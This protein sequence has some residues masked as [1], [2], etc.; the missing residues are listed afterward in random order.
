MG[1]AM[2]SPVKIV[3]MGCLL[4]MLAAIASSART[5]LHQMH[6]ILSFEATIALP[7]SPGTAAWSNDGRFLAV[8]QPVYSGTLRVVDVAARKLTDPIFASN[9]GPSTTVAWS[10]DDKV[11]A[12]VDGQK[13][14]FVKHPE[15]SVIGTVHRDPELYAFTNKGAASFTR[16]G[17]FV[18]VGCMVAGSRKPKNVAAIKIELS[19]MSIVD[20]VQL[21][22]PGEGHTSGWTSETITGGDGHIY[23]LTTNTFWPT[24]GSE[25]P[26]THRMYFS[27]FDLTD[28]K[29][30]VKNVIYMPRRNKYEDANGIMYLPASKKLALR[31]AGNG[32]LAIALSSVADPLGHRLIKPHP[33]SDCCKFY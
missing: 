14:R 2:R 12:I 28:Q 33:N 23:L 31:I 9:V 29:F 13:V 20:S 7:E 30:I 25:N 11:I 4:L 24:D 17:L 19:T 21:V 10:P 22:P 5:G 1:A 16:D 26:K 15:R 6:D 8:S 3:S 32:T 27:V 18:W